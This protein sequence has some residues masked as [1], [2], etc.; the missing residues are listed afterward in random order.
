MI[1]DIH[2][3]HPASMLLIMVIAFIGTAPSSTGSGVKITSCAILLAT[4]K[5][6]INGRTSVSIHGRS[7]ARDQIF[8]AITII[9]MSFFWILC[10]TFCLLMTEHHASFLELLFETISAFATLGVSHSIT[11][12]LSTTGKLFI[13]ITMIVGRI[14]SLTLIMALKGLRVLR[15]EETTTFTYPEERVMLT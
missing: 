10:V 7:I 15:A 2:T 6:A 12:T 5:A 3:I 4:I 8:K 1:T 13:V 11:P 14:G 9:A